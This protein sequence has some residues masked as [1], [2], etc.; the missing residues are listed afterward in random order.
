M[1]NKKDLY[2]GDSLINSSDLNIEGKEVV[3][4]NE[5]FYKISNVNKMKPFF[6]SIVSA[7]DHW[8]F[9]SST[10]AL[11]AGRK[12][13]NNALFPYYTD[14]KI[15]E[16]H[17]VT[18]NKSIFHVNKNN[19]EYLWEP[20]TKTSDFIYQNERNL[21]KNLRGN[22]VIFEEINN[23]LGLKFSYQWTTC[24]KYGFIKTSSIKNLNNEDISISLI[25]GFQNILPWGLDESVQNN[26]SNLVDAYKRNELDQDS[27]IGIFTLSA[28]IV[29]RAEPSEALKS[30]I[31]YHLGL[32]NCKVLLS[33]HQ[34]DKFRKG[35]DVNQEIDVKAEKGAYFI[36]SSISL[37]ENEKQEWLFAGDI[38]K[39]SSDIVALKENMFKNN[40]IE[41][42]NEEILNSSNELYKLVGSSDG[43]QLSSDRRRN[44]R[45]FANTLFNI[46][47]GG[48]FDKDYLVEKNDFI[49]YLDNASKKC[50]NE[51]SSIISEWPNHF[52][53]HFL[54]DSI[55]QSNSEVFKR[56][57]TEYLPIKFSRRHGDPSRPWNKFSINTRDDITGEKVLDYQGNW[58]DI[59]Q[60]WEALA[61]S[62]PQFIDGMIYRFLNASTFDGYNPYRLTKDGFD[63]ETIE[64]DNPWSYIGYW[65]DHQIIYLLKFLEFTEKYFPYRLNSFL[66]KNNFVYANV[67]YEI[68]DYESIYKDPKNTIDFNFELA[69]KIEKDR[70]NEGADGAILKNYQGSIHEVNFIEK[71]LTTILA[72]LS[73]FIPGAGIWMNTQRP[74]WNDANN[75]LVGNGVSMV[76]LYY[77][78][79]FLN[80]FITILKND[81][82]SSFEISTELYHFFEKLNISFCKIDSNISNKDRK[83][84]VD[85][86]GEV[87]AEYRDRIYKSYFSGTKELVDVDR[88]IN[89]LETA[90]KLLEKTIDSNKR[91]DGLYHAYNLV[92][93]DDN[94][95]SIDRLSEMLEGQVGVLSS[96]YLSDSES[97]SVLDSLKSSA[98]FWDEQYSY[99]L[100]PNKDLL[101][102]L[103]KNVIPE[104]EINKSTLLTL[105]VKNENHQII[106]KDING[107]YHFNGLFHNA[108]CLISELE[109]L[110][111]QYNKLVKEERESI[112]EIFEAVFDHKSF[113]GRS[114]TFYGYEG[115]GSIYWHMVSKLLLATAEVTQRSINNKS[116]PKITG[117]LFDHYF[118]INEGIGVNKSPELYGAFPTDPYSH[119]PRGRGVQQPGMTGQVKEDVISRFYEL[120]FY[121]ND[122]KIIFEPTV[123]RKNE[124]IDEEKSFKFVNLDNEITYM[125][126]GKNSLAYT[127]C[128]VPIIYNL[129]DNESIKIIFHDNS[130]INIKNH[131]LDLQNSQNIFNRTNLIKAVHVRV[132]K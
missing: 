55:N 11:S 120:G 85:D 43:I 113:T 67:P 35:H 59:F 78:R 103:D 77:L 63:W 34:L 19:K 109:N 100:Y 21:Y 51:M 48:I 50:G 44:I 12:N 73:N 93:L 89:F 3:I 98:L 8:L 9:I 108:T 29:D 88:L 107:K 2:L 42:I 72:K 47:R 31:V 61:Y 125:D 90:Q 111:S 71:I 118:E 84:F 123:L 101:G 79:R 105:L 112:L 18:G 40:L 24:D 36:H 87:A 86:I 83:K 82:S 115:L 64:P 68:K 46:M 74:E 26:T 130:E 81:D 23:D 91:E 45:H 22:K 116:D 104:I 15:S 37:K 56:L 99:I 62:Y 58:R 114:G 102:F 32:D 13:S 126:L 33:S 57:A 76:T 132:I 30:N 38:N 17:D 16:S 119:T 128:Q 7:Y 92:N 65:G 94:E 110:P 96:G 49:K 1:I 106:V 117:R 27:K 20:F 5:N 54:R 121:V 66:R 75:A 97:L 25:D 122:G 28:T 60:N 95:I 4:K 124:F 127:I 80:F 41:D 53:L 14:D 69:E 129:S 131:E 10:G 6:M 52:D 39:S 70:L